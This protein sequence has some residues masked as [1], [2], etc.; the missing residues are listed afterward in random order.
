MASDARGRHAGL[1]D[2]SAEARDIFETRRERFLA[3]AAEALV[4]L[5]GKTHDVEA[6]LARCLEV[7][8]HAYAVRP[9]ALR[10]RDRR[11]LLAP[12][13]YQQP[14]MLGYSAY[15]DR[16]AGDLPGVSGKLE[17]LSELGVTYLHLL[18]LTRPRPG[19][20]DGGYAV[21][22]FAALDPR[23]GDMSDLERLAA[24]CRTR[25]MALAT[26]LVLN[27]VADTHLWARRARAGDPRYRAYFHTCEDPDEVARIE[28]RLPEIFPVA[29]PGNFTRIE[30]MG[31][32]VWTTFYSF[33]WDLNYANPEIFAEMLAI[34]LSFANR[35][36]D[37]LR[38]D[39]APFLWKRP[40]TDCR[41]LPEVHL[42]L[43][44]F[45]AFSRIAAPALAMK[46]EAVVTPEHQTAYLGE[47]AH[48]GQ[49][50]QLAYHNTLMVLAW[51]A[52]AEARADRLTGTLRR[53]PFPPAN[54]AW[55]TYIRCHDDI[56]W[57]ILEPIAQDGSAAAEIRRLAAFYAGETEGRFARGEH[58]QAD[59]A[60]TVPGTAGTTA[61]LAGLE[62]ALEEG[63]AAKIEMAIRRI[64]LLHGVIFA[65]GGIPLLYMGDEIG[66]LNDTGYRKDP[67]LAHDARWLHRPKMDWAKAEKR[68][69][70]DSVEGRLFRGFRSLA[71]ARANCPALHADTPSRALHCSNP[72]VFLMRRA[73][74]RGR[75]LL[76]ANFSDRPQQV[77]ADD[78]RRARFEFPLSDALSDRR[79]REAE[80]V[81][82]E[83]YELLWLQPE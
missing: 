25:G 13:W 77:P 79:L 16:F 47:G 42:L 63:D 11:R 22:D 54:S 71:A 83:P 56:G 6:V 67:S 30:E 12:D 17:Y 8:A 35:G 4:A 32:W 73:G 34:M 18:P 14:D 3:P 9:E 26:D 76:L 21:E 31:C 50:C 58:F 65:F 61:A 43:R 10:Q 28:A 19:E 72:H 7:A 52:L 23:L 49:E 69:D 81:P 68:H 24:A 20:S 51:S 82:L 59:P 27:H 70:A 53:M 1:Q 41:N 66:L 62:A 39:S 74:A 45:H 48:A 5:Y 2:L 15:A 55:I 75:F 33:Q 80:S 36:I 60:D 29:A 40:G 44:A 38:L 78:I 37:V 57:A 46:A 64:L